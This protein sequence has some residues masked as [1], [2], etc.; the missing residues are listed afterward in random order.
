[1][2]RTIDMTLRPAGLL[3]CALMAMT[4]LSACG[5]N[6]APAALPSTSVAAAKPADPA[7][8]ALYA[9]SCKACHAQA[10][11]GAPQTGDRGAW[12]PRLAQ[13]VDVLLDHT[14]NGFKGMPPLGSCMDC[15]EDEL[16]ALIEFM[17]GAS[18]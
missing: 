16:K 18:G 14:I 12:K 6:E 13:G 11:S 2:Y 9:Q 3:F 10:G 7:L 17:S 15:T 8:D 4:T 1:M 5:Q